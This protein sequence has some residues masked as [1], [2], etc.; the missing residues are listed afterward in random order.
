MTTPINSFSPQYKDNHFKNQ[1]ET[2]RVY[3]YL[4]TATAA[5]VV[6]A[7]GIPHKNLCRYKRELEK[8]GVLKEVYKDICRA[9]GFKASYLTTNP[10]IVA[11]KKEV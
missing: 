5:M 11:D 10:T 3:L 9:T 4:H 6:R 7:T 1:L 8:A 2:V